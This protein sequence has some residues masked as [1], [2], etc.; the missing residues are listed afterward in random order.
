[1]YLLTRLYLLTAACILSN[2]VYEQFVFNSSAVTLS[3]A[4][5]CGPFRTLSRVPSRYDT[6]I[7]LL[8]IV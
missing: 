4:L 2:G 7:G 5:E 3:A 1:M 6:F 8:G